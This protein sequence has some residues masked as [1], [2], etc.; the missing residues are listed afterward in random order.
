MALIIIFNYLS[1]TTIIRVI[2]S[3]ID[4]IKAI[5]NNL[6]SQ[7]TNKYLFDDY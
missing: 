2:T 7:S 1:F 5:N 4:T 6:I 3:I